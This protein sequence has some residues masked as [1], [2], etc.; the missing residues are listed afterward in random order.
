MDGGTSP[1]QGYGL[2]SAAT[3]NGQTGPAN[4]FVAGST[5]A[6][7][8]SHLDSFFAESGWTREDVLL[9]IGVIQVAAWLAL[10][11]LEVQK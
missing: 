2:T 7:D 3:V 10:L 5:D 4:S 8:F 9:A 1:T 6:A 11:Y